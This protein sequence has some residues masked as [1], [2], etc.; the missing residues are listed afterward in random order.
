[1]A[2]GEMDV[3]RRI[4]RDAR[5]APGAISSAWRLVSEAANLQPVLPVQATR[6]A[7][8]ALA[9]IA[10]PSASILRLRGLQAFASAR[11]RSADSARP[12]AGYRR[13]PGRARWRR[14]R[15]SARRSAGRPAR[16]RRSSCRPSCFCA[17]MPIWAVR[18]ER[19]ARRQRRRHGAVELAAELLFRQREEF[20]DAHLVEHVFQPR[21][22]AVG[23]VA[24][25][26]EHAHHRVGHHAW[27]RRAAPARRC[28][29]RNPCAR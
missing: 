21:L 6:P 5:L 17:W 13:R 26:D 15:A 29:G 27:R 8:M 22:G 23:A 7:R 28:R 16:R 19:R 4:E 20:L 18:L 24:V 11:R 10:R 14:G 9:S 1:M 2:A 12:S 25:F 3:D